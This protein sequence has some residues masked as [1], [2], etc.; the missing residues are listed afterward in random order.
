MH[1]T[2]RAAPLNQ[3]L[4][5]I[6]LAAGLALVAGCSNKDDDDDAT[7]GPEQ[8]S[9]LSGS[10][11]DL[12]V[13]LQEGTNMAAAPSPDGQ[14]IVF[15]AQGALWMI[16]AA[17]GA[18]TRLTPWTLEPT[19]PVWSPDG[20]TIVFQNY[21]PEGNYHLWAIDP[22]G[23][24]ARELTTGNWDDRE[25]AFAQPLEQPGHVV[26][27]LCITDTEPHQVSDRA[28]ALLRSLADRLVTEVERRKEETV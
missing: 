11:K 20:R 28:R 6:A 27:T 25:P 9:T 4:R 14:R 7:S 5:L 26:G 12:T 2:P 22:D 16:P 18:A 24:N 8:L 3:R 10:T 17:G 23:R 13:E 21:A 1:R 19:H 15:S